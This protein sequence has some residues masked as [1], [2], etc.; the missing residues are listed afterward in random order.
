M[1][2][3]LTVLF[4]LDQQRSTEFYAAALG[5]QPSLNVPG[6]TMFALN[7]GSDLGLMPAKGITQILDGKIPDPAAATGIPRGELYLTVDDPAAWYLRALAAGAKAIS[8][9]QPRNWG[10]VAAYCQDPDGHLIAF[11]KPQE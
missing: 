4:V 6:M 9:L 7:P 8:E 11:A 3:V 1:E 10:D 2:K 5:R